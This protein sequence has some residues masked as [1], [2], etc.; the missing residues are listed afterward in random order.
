MVTD[1]NSRTTDNSNNVELYSMGQ[2]W[3]ID[4]FDEIDEQ[5]ALT[6]LQN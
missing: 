5:Q 1:F 4:L 2:K 6:L 3:L